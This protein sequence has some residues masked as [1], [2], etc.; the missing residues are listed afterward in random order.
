MATAATSDIGRG[1]LVGRAGKIDPGANFGGDSGMVVPGSVQRIGKAGKSSNRAVTLVCGLQFGVNAVKT[2]K[3]HR[4]SI[5][6]L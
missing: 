6:K 5:K 1:E 4:F 3:N 2:H